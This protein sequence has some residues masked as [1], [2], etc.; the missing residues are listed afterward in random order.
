M[1]QDLDR[2]APEWASLIGTEHAFVLMADRVR[3]QALIALGRKTEA[4]ALLQGL[5]K[6]L[7][8]KD[9]QRELRKVRDLL[10]ELETPDIIRQKG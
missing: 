9:L 7:S 1:L 10:T 6:V 2:R 3:A 4:I 5:D 8:A